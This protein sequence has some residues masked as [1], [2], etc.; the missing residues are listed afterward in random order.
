[1]VGETMITPIS[2]YTLNVELKTSLTSLKL[3]ERYYESILDR[4]NAFIE[5]QFFTTP[6]GAVCVVTNTIESQ[7]KLALT[8]SINTYLKS[9]R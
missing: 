4:N 5:N 6:R 3:K 9:S 2:N 7:I 1:M 8:R